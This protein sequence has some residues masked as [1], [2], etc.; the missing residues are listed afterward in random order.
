MIYS[1]LLIYSI[2]NKFNDLDKTREQ[3]KFFCHMT[4][5]FF[6]Y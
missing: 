1:I 2:I 4:L 6:S 3:I 5:K